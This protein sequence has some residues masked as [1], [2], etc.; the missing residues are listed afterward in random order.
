MAVFSVV[1]PTHDRLEVLQEVLVALEAQAGAP[2]FE[3]V[4]VDDG[5][6]DGTTGWLDGRRS[7]GPPLTVLHQANRG[8]AAARNRG[9]AAAT[10]RWVAFLGDDTVPSV[11][12]L[13]AHRE[14]HRRRGDREDLAV[15]GHTGWHPRMR[16]DPFLRY[17]NEY[18]L[19]FGYALITDPDEVPFNFFYTSNL[20]LSRQLLLAEP[21]DTS[22]PHAAWED[23]EAGYRMSRRHGM[24]LTYEPAAR[25]AHD[26]PT[27]FARF[28]TRQEKAGYSAVLF[29]RLHPEL[30]GFLGLGPDGPPPLPPPGRQRRREAMVRALHK[31]S[32]IEELAAR[33]LPGRL[34]RV[35][36][37]VLRY[38]YIRGLHRGWA[39]RPALDPGAH[40]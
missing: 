15:I 21:F 7:S 28:A 11:G 35:W 18:G 17:I 9:V 8:P 16:P 5:S 39:E 20:S 12:W 37:D 30:G 32:P 40:R 34:P 1:I 31:W 14:A 13:A 26:H 19:Q 23:I 2:D 29:H 3:I 25:T 36:E 24:R 4:V 27:D 38:H 22:F 10:G 33:L 6:S